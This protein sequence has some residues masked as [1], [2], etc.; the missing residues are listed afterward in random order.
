MSQAV[1]RTG[2]SAYLVGLA[3]EASAKN[4][5]SVV[6]EPLNVFLNEKYPRDM[7]GWRVKYAKPWATPL[8]KQEAIKKMRE[9]DPFNPEI[10]AS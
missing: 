1:Q 8:D 3:L 6:G 2:S 4:G 10:P 5:N 7:Y 9:L